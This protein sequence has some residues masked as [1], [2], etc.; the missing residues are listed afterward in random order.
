MKFPAKLQTLMIRSGETQ[1]SLGET[2]GVAHTTVGRW[3][4]G[5]RPRAGVVA[6]IAAHFGISVEILLDDE[7]VLPTADQQ[8][9][10]TDQTTG[11]RSVSGAQLSEKWLRLSKDERVKIADKII[12]L[13][14]KNIKD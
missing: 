6:K 4:L 13:L 8:N 5:V 2:L 3:L 14:T 10:L 12:E 9:P 11:K 7:A 1:E